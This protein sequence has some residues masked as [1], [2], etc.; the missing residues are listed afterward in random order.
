M[1][2]MARDITGMTNDEVLS[3]LHLILVFM[4]CDQSNGAHVKTLE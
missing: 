4:K 1:D 2:E 3:S